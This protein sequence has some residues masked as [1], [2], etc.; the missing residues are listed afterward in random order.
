MHCFSI[1]LI[2]NVLFPADAARKT[3]SVLFE[4]NSLQQQLRDLEQNQREKQTETQRL[5]QK[6]LASHAEI[7]QL[8]LH[9]DKL[10]ADLLEVTIV[11]V[12]N[13]GG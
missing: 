2:P 10:K 1:T 5:Q 4:R 3:E 13:L 9:A 11:T 12:S 7:S 8:K 6:Y